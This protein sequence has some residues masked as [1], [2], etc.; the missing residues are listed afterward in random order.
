V[1]LDRRAADDDELD[2]IPEEH[3]QQLT[4][5]DVYRVV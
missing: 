5:V 3:L 1:G 2:A 4:A